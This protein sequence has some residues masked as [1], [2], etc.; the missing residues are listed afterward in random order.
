MPGEAAA[1]RAA[2]H[3]LVGEEGVQVVHGVDLGCVVWAQEKPSSLRRRSIS[4]RTKTAFSR[5]AAGL[6]S[7]WRMVRSR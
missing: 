1:R 2:P 7:P 3:D 4:A 5:I 6:V